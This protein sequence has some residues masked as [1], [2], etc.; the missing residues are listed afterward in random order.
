MQFLP[1]GPHV[2]DEL[3]QSLE[4]ENVVLFCGAGV[5]KNVGLPD[6]GELVMK[7]YRHLHLP[8][9]KSGE[10]ENEEEYDEFGAKHFDRVLGLLEARLGNRA[11]VRQAVQE[12]LEIP[13]GAPLPF[14]SS[15]L[16]LARTPGG[17]CRLVTT[18]LDRGFVIAAPGPFPCDVAPMLPPARADKWKRLAHLHGLIGADGRSLEDLI[19]TSAD[20]GD[21][22][23][24]SGWASSLT[25]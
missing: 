18:N 7:V 2:P 25:A 14:H 24:T 10:P 9:R 22:Y 21:A 15:L 4:D 16:E 5:S 17:A 11:V 1:D 8:V 23:I 19:L 6:F 13:P 12:I 20:F 3:I